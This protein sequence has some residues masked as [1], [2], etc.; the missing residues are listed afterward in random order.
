MNSIDTL[1]KKLVKYPH[2]DIVANPYHEQYAVNNLRQYFEYMFNQVGKRIL[3]VAEAPGYKGCRITGIPLTSGKVF[4]EI[5]HPLLIA[6]KDKIQL[7]CIESENTA[8]IVWKYLSTKKTTPLFWN[9]FPFHPHHKGNVLSNRIPNDSEVKFGSEILSELYR[10]YQPEFI[11][12]IGRRGLAVL[13]QIFPEQSFDYIR[14][15]SYGGKRRFIEDMDNII[16]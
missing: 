1:L 8:T 6:L 7:P 4:K 9:S 2:S 5:S 16:E 10:I 3:L 15:P 12:G 13:Q 11:A 14:H